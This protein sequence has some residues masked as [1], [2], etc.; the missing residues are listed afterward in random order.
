MAISFTTVLMLLIEKEATLNI[1]KVWNFCNVYFVYILKY[2]SERKKLYY[3]LRTYTFTEILWVVAVVQS[4]FPYLTSAMIASF[5]TRPSSRSPAKKVT[6]VP[7]TVPQT[8]ASVQ[9]MPSF[10]LPPPAVAAFRLVISK[11]LRAFLTFISAASFS[12]DVYVSL[13]MFQSELRELFARFH[14]I[15]AFLVI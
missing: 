4:C 14:E 15:N 13:L 9:H 3:Q 10:S 1:N 11:R 5:V 8:D 12:T 7:L 2:F 6:S